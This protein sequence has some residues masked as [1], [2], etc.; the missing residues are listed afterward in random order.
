MESYFEPTTHGGG[1]LKVW[2]EAQLEEVKTALARKIEAQGEEIS[3]LKK[4]PNA[5]S[6][7]SFGRL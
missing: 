1:N 3:Q 4:K 7:R 2:L 5:G 6:R